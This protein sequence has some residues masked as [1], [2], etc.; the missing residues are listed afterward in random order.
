MSGLMLTQ[1][2]TLPPSFPQTR[3]SSGLAFVCGAYAD[4]A[5]SV[6]EVGA[7]ANSRRRGETEK[8]FTPAPAVHQN[9]TPLDSRLRGS[10]GAR[11][12][13]SLEVQS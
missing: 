13:P 1:C 2:L 11:V 6:I 7:G 5:S 3:E 9:P 8:N 10:D 4:G 12:V